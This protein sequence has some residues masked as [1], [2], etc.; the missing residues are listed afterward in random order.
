MRKTISEILFKRS[1]FNMG[2]KAVIGIL[3]VIII[4][5]LGIVK[6]CNSAPKDSLGTLLEQ[7]MEIFSQQK[8]WRNC[9][10]KEYSDFLFMDS[11]ERIV[12]CENLKR[13]QGSSYTAVLDGSSES[14]GDANADNKIFTYMVVN[15]SV[16]TLFVS[17]NSRGQIL[18]TSW[19]R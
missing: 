7:R 5:G 13:F 15:D 11:L 8:L 4:G 1:S 3:G 12:T 18:S 2:G 10:D 16:Q 17:C 9:F 19:Q 6:K 14:S